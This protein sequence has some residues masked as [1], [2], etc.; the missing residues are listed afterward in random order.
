[1]T[2]K[3]RA[4]DVLANLI[5]IDTDNSD[6]EISDISGTVDDVREEEFESNLVLEDFDMEVASESGEED[7]DS[8]VDQ[9]GNQTEPVTKLTASQRKKLAEEVKMAQYAEKA[10]FVDESR[11]DVTSKDDIIWEKLLD[12]EK[13]R[14]RA[15]IPTFSART[16]PS[17]YACTRIDET[18]LSAFRLII[19]DEML[20]SI[21]QYTNEQISKK[22]KL[23]SRTLLITYFFICV[24]YFVK[25]KHL[26]L[27]NK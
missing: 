20:V 8:E 4:A 22:I 18:A 2:T 14:I 6:D 7:E 24:Q 10:L 9:E 1:M 21:V 25:T 3:L 17:L 27:E 11:L 16:G 5:D 26:L 15:R 23:C 13:T 12:G 19:S